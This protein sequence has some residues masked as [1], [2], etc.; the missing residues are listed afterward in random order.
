MVGAHGASL[1]GWPLCSLIELVGV[2]ESRTQD[3]DNGDPSYPISLD[4]NFVSD[5]WI[6]SIGK[7]QMVGGSNGTPSP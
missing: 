6:Y 1:A 2:M 4:N 3:F 7:R 5:V